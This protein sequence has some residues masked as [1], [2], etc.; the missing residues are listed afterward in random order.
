MVIFPL[1]DN[2]K[3]GVAKRMSEV[4]GKQSR[5]NTRLVRVEDHDDARRLLGDLGSDPAGVAIMSR[6]ML[7]LVVA[8]D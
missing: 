4:S 3:Q 6:K 7:H 8:V 5:F 1:S 2:V